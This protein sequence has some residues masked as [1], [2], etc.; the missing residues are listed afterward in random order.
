[1][2]LRIVGGS[3]RGRRLYSLPGRTTRPTPEIVREALFNILGGGIADSRFTDF[4]AGT[5]AVG[6]EALSRGAARVTFVE[7]SAGALKVLAKNL[8][9]LDCEGRYRLRPGDAFT[10]KEVGEENYIFAAPPYAEMRRM[11]QLAQ[12]LARHASPEVCWIL[13]HPKVFDISEIARIWEPLETRVY[14]S[15]ALSFFIKLK[16]DSFNR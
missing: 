8:T 1:V 5:G 4:F 12:H 16:E 2:A 3:H 13:Q 11:G 15:N 10:C 7:K 6:L 14:G 9:L